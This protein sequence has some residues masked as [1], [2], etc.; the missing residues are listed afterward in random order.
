MTLDVLTFISDKGGDP[1]AIRDSQRKRGHS[2]EVVDEVIAMYS[3][4]VK[5][6]LTRLMSKSVSLSMRSCI[7]DFELNGLNKEANALQKQIAAK[8][9]VP[10]VAHGSHSRMTDTDV[11]CF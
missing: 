8:K 11:C 9:K 2:V 3:D 7:V 5:R 10:V 6:E 1:E 4:W